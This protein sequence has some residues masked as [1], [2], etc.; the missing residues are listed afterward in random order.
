MGAEAVTT[1]QFWQALNN[2]PSN[3]PLFLRIKMRENAPRTK[4]F[5]TAVVGVVL[6]EVSTLLLGLTS[7]LL[8]TVALVFSL[9]LPLM[10]LAMVFN[11]TV[12]AVRWTA[13]VGGTIAREREMRRYDLLC[14]LPSGPVGAC[15]TICAGCLDRDSAFKSIPRFEKFP[16][17]REQLIFIVIIATLVLVTL[18]SE[19]RVTEILLFF[20]CLIAAMLGFYVDYVQ[21]A[22]FASLIGMLTSIYVHSQNDA[23]LLG[24]LAF[25]LL[26]ASTYLFTA[27]VG[28][29]IA[30]MILDWHQIPEWVASFS[31]PFL[32]LATFYGVRE[33]MIVGL[34]RLVTHRLKMA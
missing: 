11:S 17:R 13:S 14:L 1:W 12:Y 30:P 18:I 24:V 29:V 21:S 10:L 20:V 33:G 32:W 27:L 7:P 34:L 4:T 9:I 3:H 5:A 25:L 6:F 8:Q 28:V 22:V 23:R 15:M 2:P 31:L 16:I 26:Q 19:E